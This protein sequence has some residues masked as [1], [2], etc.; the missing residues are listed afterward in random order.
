M[1]ARPNDEGAV[2]VPDAA[3]TEGDLASELAAF[4]ADRL[5]DVWGA[6][7]RIN[8]LERLSGGA[9]RETWAAKSVSSE[10][11]SHRLILRRDPKSVAVSV[12]LPVEAAAMRA[13][14]AVG[15]PGPVI[16][17]VFE[18]IDGAAPHILMERIDGETIP[19]RI[20]RD[21]RYER[22]RLH[23]A[24][25]LG[26]VLALIHSIDAAQIAGLGTVSDPVA[27]MLDTLGEGTALSPA[28]QLG[29]RYLRDNP[30]PT[31]P[32]GLVHGDFRLGN[33]I[34]S[35]SGLAAVLDWE[36]VHLGDQLEDLGWLCAKVWRFGSPLPVGGV[37]SRSDLL[38]SYAQVTGWRP[39]EQQLH[40]WELF[41]TV[42]WGL[43]C[44]VQA[45][46][47]CSG[48]ERSIE[49][50]AIG[51]RACEQDFDVLLSL[52]MAAPQPA[53]DV[54]ETPITRPASEAPHGQP[55]QTVLLEAVRELVQEVVLPQGGRTE[56]LGRVASNVLKM[57]QRQT[58]LGDE[59]HA[60][61]LTRLAALG[62]TDD[63]A[64][65]IAIAEGSLDNRMPEVV[66]TV[67]ASVHAQ[68]LVANPAHLARPDC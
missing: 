35:E 8:S 29:L 62:C 12:S 20:L 47:H 63:E 36:Q 53:E 50:A 15:V 59:Q 55:T 34:V 19:R 14:S 46:R 26:R 18:G 7:V 51:R 17:D 44:G 45:R 28:L 22:A 4:L 49:L 41:A 5:S 61:H 54:L 56:F 16:H 33:V 43:I 10:G 64:L 13:A 40:W 37:G 65:S 68:L 9:S 6:R 24:S 38:D 58:I 42:R 11:R 52:G 32:L 23:L 30:C 60:A 67:V 21:S 48:A 1:I 39:T 27:Q 25:D 31:G 57:V 66:S 3:P 2:V